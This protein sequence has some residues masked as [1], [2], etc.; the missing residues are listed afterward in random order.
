MNIE[1]LLL[2]N[3]FEMINQMIEEGK[4]LHDV[5]S[6]FSLKEVLAMIKQQKLYFALF[7]RTF[8]GIVVSKTLNFSCKPMQQF[9]GQIA[10]LQN[11]IER[12]KHEKFTV[13]FTV[14]PPV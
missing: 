4:I 11:E 10:L 13:V 3:D 2:N 1:R 12:W 5:K 6:S 8:S 7:T 14:N 9:H